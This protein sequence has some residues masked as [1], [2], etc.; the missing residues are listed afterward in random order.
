MEKQRLQNTLFA[1]IILSETSHVFCCV[2]P[3]IFSVL[4]LMAGFGL[5]SVVPGWLTD[6][7]DLMHRWELPIIAVSGV[8]LALGWGLHWYSKKIDCHD[9]G[10]GHG[11]CE[12]K[13][14]KTKMI[15]QAATLLF[16]VN[17]SIYLVFHRGM[18]MFVD[19][20]APAVEQHEGHAH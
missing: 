5:V 8:V 3:T 19:V 16:V 1:A 4:S 14:D 15:M 17:V 13:K 12:P 6:F 2:L 7:H 18:E 9:H 10:C 20:P 11:P